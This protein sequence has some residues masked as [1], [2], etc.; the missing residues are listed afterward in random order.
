MTRFRAVV[1]SVEEKFHK[2]YVRGVGKN[3]EF[4]DV[5]IGWFVRLSNSY[6]SLCVGEG[7]PDLSPGD[8][9]LVTIEKEAR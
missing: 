5:G 1:I 7:E 3:A 8:I 9:V 4:R 2:N 6:E